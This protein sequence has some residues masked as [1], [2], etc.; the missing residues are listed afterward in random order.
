[1]RTLFLQIVGAAAV[2]GCSERPVL[3]PSND[4]STGSGSGTSTPTT[5][6]SS[7]EATTTTDASTG[8]VVDST[9]EAP[10]TTTGMTAGTTTTGLTT[11]ESTSTT[12]AEGTTTASQGETT[13]TADSTT[14][15]LPCYGVVDEST[16]VEGVLCLAKGVDPCAP[17]DEA[18]YLS[19]EAHTQAGELTD[20][21][22]SEL[23]P[24]SGPTEQDGQCCYMVVAG[25]CLVPG[26]PLV[27]AGRAHVA[28]PT[29]RDGWQVHL[30]WAPP[31]MSAAT[32]DAGAARWTRAALAEHASIAAFARFSLQLLALGA[33]PDLLLAAHAALVD[34]VEHARASFAIASALAGVPVGAGPL[35]AALGGLSQSRL[36]FVIDTFHEGCVGESIA[37][38]IAGLA[39]ARCEDPVLRALLERIAEDE[40]RHAALAWSAVRWALAQPDAGP[41]RAALAALQAPSFAADDELCELPAL[42]LLSSREETLLAASLWREVIAPC[43]DAL[44]VVRD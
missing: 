37:A 35:P 6:A 8:A 20:C 33:P 29:P 24:L 16:L 22:P 7:V 1:M 12:T 5:Q 3:D 32:R 36:E 10:M 13:T 38:A 14:A 43:R 11:N 21:S 4:T 19:S 31:A 34:E 41:L 25:C 2:H 40:L 39:A 9:G 42:G 15:D 27:V 18:C 17:C 30:P 44:L 28:S 23:R 26:R